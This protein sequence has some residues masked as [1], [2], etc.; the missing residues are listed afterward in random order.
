M[1]KSPLT[2]CGKAEN[3]KM[4]CTS[5]GVPRK[6]QMYRLAAWLATGIR[7]CRATAASTPSPIPTSCASTEIHSVL[8]A[9]CRM[10]ASKR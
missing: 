7:R 8:S 9:P 6:N 3:Q 4:S 1:L 5:S 10:S 2:N